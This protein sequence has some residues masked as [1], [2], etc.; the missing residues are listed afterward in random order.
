MKL[1]GRQIDDEAIVNLIMKRIQ[2]K[3]CQ[4]QGWVL[5]DFPK[6]R[7]QALFLAKKGLVPTNLIVL[8]VNP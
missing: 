8:R 3:D 1:E 6:T 2:M 7:N 4:T 5:D